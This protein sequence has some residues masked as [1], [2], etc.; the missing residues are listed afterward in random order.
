[1][2]QE[3]LVIISGSLVGFLLGML[4]GGGSIL[5]VPLLLYV[6]GMADVHKAIGTSAAAVAI[7]AGMNL[8]IHARSHTVK[9][10]CA[11]V[12]AIFGVVGAAAG[13]TLGKWTQPALLLGLFGVLMVGV[14]GLMLLGKANGHNPD[15]RLTRAS[16]HWL[17]PRLA[18]G[19]LVVGFLAG[20]FGIGGGFLIVPGLVASTAM[21]LINAIGSSL[22]SVSS[23]GITTAANYAIE[24]L[25]NWRYVLLFSV[26]SLVGG[27]LGAWV[28]RH[29]AVRRRLLSVLF[30]VFVMMAG[31]GVIWSAV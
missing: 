26:G 2:L 24:G 3:L 19:G 22:I 28:S 17:L 25:V 14:G 5:A 13:S 8:M 9:W 27:F 20:F 1:M 11:V 29:L 23:F 30:A 4:G 12:F 18:I 21:P 10:P 6:V 31:V 7:S 15:V 16:A